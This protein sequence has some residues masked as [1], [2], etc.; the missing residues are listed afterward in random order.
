MALSKSE[1]QNRITAIRKARDSGV[2]SIGHGETRTTFRS[3]AEMNTILGQLEKE[4]AA[5]DGSTKS[6]VKYISQGT[7][8]L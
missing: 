7:K 8:G 3:L 5:L 1:L 6:R 4:L 2:L